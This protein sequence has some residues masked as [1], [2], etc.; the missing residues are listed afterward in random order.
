MLHHIS[1][2]VIDLAP[3][4]A[5][6][7]AAL[8]P[9]GCVRVWSFDTAVGYGPAG[10]GD[11]LALKLRPDRPAPAPSGF[12]V[13]FSAPDR[14]AVDAFWAAAM[15]HGGTDRG[16]P[17]LRPHFGDHYYAA[18]VLDPDGHWLEAVINRP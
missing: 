14:A 2:P 4:G 8:R 16:A 15:A 17:G 5:F 13:A 18:F 1:L 11:K 6:Y 12:H 7:D 10:G 3:A 9:L